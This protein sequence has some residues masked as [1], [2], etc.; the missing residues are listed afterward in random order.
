MVV[1]SGYIRVEASRMRGAASIAVLLASIATAAAA[2]SCRARDWLCKCRAASNQTAPQLHRATAADGRLIKY[3]WSRTAAD[4]TPFGAPVFVMGSNADGQLCLGLRAASGTLTTHNFR[5]APTKVVALGDDN[6]CVF[7]GESH[8]A[9]VKLDG[10]V[11]ACGKLMETKQ[12]QG[13][14]GPDRLTSYSGDTE[15]WERKPATISAGA[16]VAVG[17]GGP[18]LGKGIPLEFGASAVELPDSCCADGQ[19]PDASCSQCGQMEVWE[20]L[21]EGSTRS[22]V[23]PSIDSIKERLFRVEPLPAGLRDDPNLMSNFES[24]LRDIGS[25]LGEGGKGKAPNPLSAPTTLDADPVYFPC[26]RDYSPL[27]TGRDS[28][29]DMHG[30]PGTT[31]ELAAHF[32]CHQMFL[33]TD[34]RVAAVGKNNFGQLG[35]GWGGYQSYSRQRA[36]SAVLE[37]QVVTLLGFDNQAVS[38][39]RRHTVVLKQ[40]RCLVEEKQSAARTTCSSDEEIQYDEWMLIERVQTGNKISRI[41]NSATPC[42]T[43]FGGLYGSIDGSSVVYGSAD[44]TV[45]R[46]GTDGLYSA[47]CTVPQQTGR[48][49]SFNIPSAG[50]HWIK[51]DQSMR[52]GECKSAGNVDLGRCGCNSA[53]TVTADGSLDLSA[54]QPPGLR[55]GL[56]S[57]GP[58]AAVACGLCH[59]QVLVAR[60][61]GL[62]SI[63]VNTSGTVLFED[64]C[65]CNPGTG[66]A[67]SGGDYSVGGTAFLKSNQSISTCQACDM[68]TFSPDALLVNATDQ[69]KMVSEI[70]AAGRGACSFCGSGTRSG[71]TQHENGV[72]RIPSG[73]VAAISGSKVCRFCEKGSFTLT[74][75]NAL[76]D[77]CV[78]CAFSSRCQF[79]GGRAPECAENSEGDGCAIC[80]ELHY[81]KAGVCTKC[82]EDDNLAKQAIAIACGLG[83]FFTI[84]FIWRLSDFKEAEE[85]GKL[86]DADM[87]ENKAHLTKLKDVNSTV[88]SGEGPSVEKAAQAAASAAA[89]ASGF[90]VSL[91]TSFATLLPHMQFTSIAF[92]M[93]SVGFPDA[94]KSLAE[95]LAPL[96]SY[97]V[98][99]QVA[100]ECTG[101]ISTA[102][103]PSGRTATA[104]LVKFF[105]KG[106]LWPIIALIFVILTA[107]GKMTTRHHR[108]NAIL[109][110][111]SL[112]LMVSAKEI[113]GFTKYTDVV[114][115]N[116]TTTRRLDMLPDYNILYGT[117]EVWYNYGGPE[118]KTPF[119]DI[120]GYMFFTSLGWI[121]ALFILVLVPGRIMWRIWRA[122]RMVAEWVELEIPEGF[123]LVPGQ[124]AGTIV[125]GT[126]RWTPEFMRAYGWFY[127]KYDV[128]AWWYEIVV[129]YRKVGL[130]GCA[131]YFSSPGMEFWFASGSLFV[132]VVSGALQHH[133]SPFHQ[134]THK[135]A[136]TR[137][138]ASVEQAEGQPGVY[139]V[140]HDGHDGDKLTFRVPAAV[141]ATGDPGAV[142]IAHVMLRDHAPDG[143]VDSEA[144]PSDNLEALSLASLAVIYT[145]ALLTSW[146]PSLSEGA[147]GFLIT[148]VSVAATL[149]PFVLL[150][151]YM[152]ASRQVQPSYKD[153]E[154]ASEKKTKEAP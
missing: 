74:I 112:L 38:A 108:T 86:L 36:L 81:N 47:D 141:G 82:E 131:V 77:Q 32:A 80:L 5:A 19:P 154:L 144:D 69:Q 23:S 45:P 67:V 118:S 35:V 109:A 117:D 57:S 125:I 72:T 143:D 12:T 46:S 18:S 44:C 106:L 13:I 55:K 114:L 115:L 103:S 136:A 129:V 132:V 90:A 58:G 6:A 31:Y 87:D 97:D 71:P 137:V 9:V 139:L 60:P 95:A 56:T 16:A 7:A 122:G 54:V 126:E 83:F 75:K 73:R 135:L 53:Q 24:R 123:A 121:F 93:P 62:S 33:L 78:A 120:S 29:G 15:L 25:Q 42:G 92:S 104:A 63:A 147:A 64:A 85:Y 39:G 22:M 61:G 146:A 130:A 145:I 91:S 26:L 20:R 76:P 148:L 70:T 113:F 28:V 17:D 79:T 48:K 111:F 11:F 21:R 14:M 89:A 153:E 30:A 40:S 34:G 4:P 84:R 133:Y 149:A 10:R 102:S 68:N 94:L 88:P 127:L 105:L 138:I 98:T 43:A 3:D 52:P 150:L 100:V 51:D 124:P 27:A 152:R 116:G 142:L 50:A 59:G 2:P 66:V 140:R 110:S 151:K 49:T 134:G 41:C 128:W 1:C 65:A 101:F 99:S 8:T 37:P 119:F 107:T 96:F